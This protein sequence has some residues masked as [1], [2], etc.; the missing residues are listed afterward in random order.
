MT[1]A[2]DP[3]SFPCFW[4]LLAFVAPSPNQPHGAVSVFPKVPR[5][6]PKSPLI[7]VRAR[8][9]TLTGEQ[10]KEIRFHMSLNRGTGFS[11]MNYLYLPATV[12]KR[13][14]RPLR[15]FSTPTSPSSGGMMRQAVT[16]VDR[17]LGTA[18]PIFN[19]TA[20]YLAYLVHISYRVL[21][22]PV[23]CT[24]SGNQDLK[25]REFHVS[26]PGI[27]ILHLIGKSDAEQYLIPPCL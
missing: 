5:N 16:K 24:S 13:F 19:D 20:T 22:H 9:E 23:A 2:P 17:A 8:R 3:C 26:P 12:A 1:S 10:A 18:I 21:R 15:Y 11:S 25:R 14:R 6:L 27:S 4:V 7:V